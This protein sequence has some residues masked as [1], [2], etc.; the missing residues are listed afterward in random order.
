MTPSSLRRPRSRVAAAGLAAALLLAACSSPEDPASPATGAAP[1]ETPTT[2]TTASPSPSPTETAPSAEL[3]GGGHVMFPERRIIALYGTPGTPA[4]GVLGEHDVE[5]AVALAKEKAEEYQA[6]SEEPV[7]P[8]FEIITTIASASPGADGNYSIAHT[9]DRLEPLIDA[10]EE[11]DIHVILDL[12]P[13]RNTFL[14]QAKMYEDLLTR[15]H[16]SLALDPEWRLPEPDMRHIQTVGHVQASEI[17]EVS[18]WLAEL[19]REHD[20]PQKMLIVH[21]FEDQMIRN[22]ADLDASHEELALTLHMDGHGHRQL[23]LDT[24]ERVTTDLPEG[25]W[26]AWKS[27]IDEDTPTW[28]PEETFDLDPKPW[29]VSYQ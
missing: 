15:P 2:P 27:F 1:A 21:Q 26:P 4:M 18:E 10:A 25:M 29:F 20:L 14:T 5:G 7:Q 3:P 9:D 19:V 22:R 13:G 16:V 8:G 24:Y 23:K 12:Q 6:F 17:N 28:T 11:N